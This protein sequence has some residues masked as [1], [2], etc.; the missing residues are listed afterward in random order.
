MARWRGGPPYRRGG[1][2]C[3][4]PHVHAVEPPHPPTR[5]RDLPGPRSLDQARSRL[6]PRV[7]R[8]VPGSGIEVRC[9][10]RSRRGESGHRDQSGWDVLDVLQRPDILIATSDNLIAWTPLEDVNGTLL[11]VLSP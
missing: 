3:L 4:R 1:G 11:K 7:W 6:R 5:R 2:R 8:Q 9:D 10:P